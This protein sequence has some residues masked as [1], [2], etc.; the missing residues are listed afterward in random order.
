VNKRLNGPKNNA[1]H[2]GEDRILLFLSDIEPRYLDS[3]SYKKAIRKF[4]HHTRHFLSN[5]CDSH[6]MIGRGLAGWKVMLFP[7]P[8][9]SVSCRAMISNYLL[10]SST[11]KIHLFGWNTVGQSIGDF[12]Q[13]SSVRTVNQ[14]FKLF[15]TKHWWFITINT[16]NNCIYRCG[17]LLYRAF[18]M[19]SG[20]TK[21]YCRKTV[22]HVVCFLLGNS[23]A[24]EFCMPTF[25]NTLSVPSS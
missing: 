12:F 22:G 5:S 6:V 21:M 19:Y 24:S 1:G 17:K 25:R 7:I 3:P 9:W 11:Y 18:H 15:M 20:I 8:S 16:T 2:F 23:P 14:Y 4:S 10:Y 13:K